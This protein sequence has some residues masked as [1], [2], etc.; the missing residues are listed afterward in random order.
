MLLAIMVSVL[1]VAWI[2]DDALITLR[3]AL[4]LTHGWGPGFNATEAVQ[5][6]T[7]PL[8]FLIWVGVG[9]LSHQWILGILVVS[10]CFTGAA[11]GLVLWSTRSVP[12]LIISG[13]LLL[14]SN[15]FIEYATS[16]LE[17]PLS[18]L[19]VAALLAISLRP[20][21]RDFPTLV[22][23]ILV[24]LSAAALLLS[25]LDYIV[26]L[27]PIGSY[28][29]FKYR[30][31]LPELCVALASLLIPLLAWFVWSKSTYDTWL[32]NTYEAKR[33]LAI[34][35]SEL[36]IQ[37]L[38]YMWV[39]FE[40]D[41][42][43]LVAI[44]VGVLVAGIAGSWI[45]RWWA[46]GTT[47]YL[48]YVIAV[49]GDFMAGRFVAV[50]VL[51]SVFLLTVSRIPGFEVQT[52]SWTRHGEVVLALSIVGVLALG[53]VLSGASP[54]SF[55]NPQ[56]ARWDV[57]QNFNAGVSDERGT[58]VALGRSFKT[59]LDH[60]SLEF[61]NP[62][63]VGTAWDGGFNRELREI[64]RAATNWPEKTQP[65]AAPID[66]LDFCGFLGTVGIAT[67]PKAQL[68]DRC[69]LT[70]AFLAARS[71][72]PTRAF[73]WKPGHFERTLPEGYLQAMITGNPDVMKDP[74]DSFF[75][76]ELWRRIRPGLT[77]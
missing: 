15:A 28:A 71:Y 31:R 50:P 19:A 48:L 72:S 55:A 35:E 26:L 18:Y 64:D 49:G 51:I 56:A 25:R 5:S 32:P 68:I 33:N 8:W 22:M 44:A 76:K 62:E 23:P 13:G 69:A 39:T 27:A 70:D 66:T 10:M 53:A 75:L 16:G 17:N 37:G 30:K 38:R 43:S 40:H 77:E 41:P 61:T 60:L 21:H 14:L 74:G 4:N 34:P 29:A 6:Y 24:G 42:I 46:A 9:S 59:Y 57:D 11:V 3:T 63:F 12:R 65:L 7:H 1:R 2:G 45:F 58:Y 52:S 20:H 47:C 73:A 54:V 36:F 67:G